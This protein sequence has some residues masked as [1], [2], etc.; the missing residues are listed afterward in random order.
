AGIVLGLLYA[1]QRLTGALGIR[2][3][4]G[5]GHDIRRRVAGVGFL[6]RV[7]DLAVVAFLVGLRVDAGRA[8]GGVFLTLGLVVRVGVAPA[9]VLQRTLA[10]LVH[11]KERRAVHVFLGAIGHAQLGHRLPAPIRVDRTAI[12]GAAAQQLHVV[13]LVELHVAEAGHADGALRCRLLIQR[14][15]RQLIAAHLGRVLRHDLVRELAGLAGG[16]LEERAPHLRVGAVDV[17]RKAARR[18]QLLL[19]GILNLLPGLLERFVLHACIGHLGLVGKGPCV[20]LVILLRLG[21]RHAVRRGAQVRLQ[22]L[23]HLA[24][25]DVL[26]I[27]LDR[28]LHHAL[29]L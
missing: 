27:V 26:G 17:L 12:V 16:R 1:A 23:V 24:A 13:L 19:H 5:L 22:R 10:Q 15:T 25:G 18:V 21:E 20:V 14:R 8:H 9:L 3:V 7:L 2:V 11:A 6:G 29:G 4:V 28:K